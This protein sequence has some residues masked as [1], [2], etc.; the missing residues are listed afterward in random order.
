MMLAPMLKHGVKGRA[1]LHLLGCTMQYM[2]APAIR[3]TRVTH[4]GEREPRRQI[5]ADAQRRKLNEKKL[6]KPYTCCTFSKA[7]YCEVGEPSS[8]LRA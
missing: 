1:S 2:H 5:A 3:H 8:L 7:S 6:R 4:L